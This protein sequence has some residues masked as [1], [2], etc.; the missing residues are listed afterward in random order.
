MR[1]S[2]L[3][4]FA[5]LWSFATLFH[6][7]AYT[8]WHEGI[9]VWLVALFVIWAIF[10]DTKSVLLLS[11]VQVCE[12]VVNMTPNNHWLI[13]TFV[14]I[15]II[16]FYST[17]INNPNA[18][19]SKM[20][21]A[22]KRILL[23]VYI[24]ALLHKLNTDFLDHNVS[25]GA[26]FYQKFTNRFPFLPKSLLFEISTIWI[27]LIIEI[28]LPICLSIDWTRNTTI[29]IAL[30]F[31][32]TIGFN[33]LSQFW[34]FSSTVYA[35]LFLFAP[36]ECSDHILKFMKDHATKKNYYILY[37]T[38]FLIIYFSYAI[39][40]FDVNAGL[41][42]WFLYCVLTIKIVSIGSATIKNKTFVHKKTVREQHSTAN[43][44]TKL[45]LILVVFNGLNPYLGLK[46][47]GTFS[48]FSNLRTELNST[49]HLF[50]P[51]SLQIFDYQKSK[52]FHID[53]KLINLTTTN[54]N[55]ISKHLLKFKPITNNRMC[56]R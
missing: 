2:Q 41:I 9:F 28:L 31:H 34:N 56:T 23:I 53:N 24:F 51:I 50:I 25:C 18:D 16:I 26:L 55:I 7:M 36:T 3:K 14:N 40:G 29:C 30:I 10:I 52:K 48:M 49:N 43:I 32:G 15:I 35:I 11:I 8:K 44:L 45:T 1:E 39:K 5:I 46:T 13:T 37:T 54:T 27:T 17:I 38:F 20:F 22:I 6:Y 47:E 42:C 21:N 19:L 33:P 12:V 4:V